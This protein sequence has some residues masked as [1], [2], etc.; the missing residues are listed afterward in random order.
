MARTSIAREDAVAAVLATAATW[1]RG[2]RKR[3]GKAFYFIPSSGPSSVVYMTA[4]DGCTCPAAR[5]S[6]SGDCKH[7]IAVRRHNEQARE[8]YT[9]RRPTLDELYDQHLVSAF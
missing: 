8:A 1:T 6:Y 7:Q 2:R 3:D 4:E 9:R 5:N